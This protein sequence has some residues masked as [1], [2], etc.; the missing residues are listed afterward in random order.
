MTHALN[1]LGN[2]LFGLI[3]LVIAGI[4]MVEGFM[5]AMLDTIGIHG[6][7]QRAVLTLVLVALIV[8]AFR[9]FGRAFGLLAA[10]FLTLLLLQAL[11]GDPADGVRAPAR[12]A[13]ASSAAWRI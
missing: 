12:Q 7:V 8:A 13:D 1:L 11:F 10:V 2:M 5:A 4:V 9:A 6:Q 3:G